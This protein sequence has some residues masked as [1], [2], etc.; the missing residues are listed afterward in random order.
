MLNHNRMGTSHMGCHSF[1]PNPGTRP[2]TSN[3][4][5]PLALGWQHRAT[6]TAL[7]RLR[8]E[9]FNTLPH[10]LHQ[11]LRIPVP[12]LPDPPR[13]SASTTSCTVCT[14][15]ALSGLARRPPRSL[16]TVITTQTRLGELNV[17]HVQQAQLAIDTLNTL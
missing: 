8:D 3:S 9:L 4:R 7:A 2:P 11:R 13:P 15:A 5:R 17:P 14:G 16:C 12:P 1:R 10:P 6:T